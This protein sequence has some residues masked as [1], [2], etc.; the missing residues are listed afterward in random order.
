MSLWQKR[1]F[2]FSTALYIVV[3]L[4]FFK[5][6]KCFILLSSWGWRYESALKTRNLPLKCP[7]DLQRIVPTVHQPHDHLLWHQS[8]LKW[9]FLKIHGLSSSWHT[10]RLRIDAEECSGLLS[11]LDHYG[12][13]TGWVYWILL[14]S[15]FWPHFGKYVSLLWRWYSGI[16]IFYR[17]SDLICSGC[18]TYVFNL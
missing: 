9:C 14:H 11:S 5:T 17:D 12:F 4:L 8:R 7:T 6:M 16:C 3:F 18:N 13:D 15:T 1:R 2:L 10:V